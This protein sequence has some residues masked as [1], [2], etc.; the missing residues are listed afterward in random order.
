MQT[1]SERALEAACDEERYAELHTDLT[2][3][4]MYEGTGDLKVYHRLCFAS[5][6]PLINNSFQQTL[7][8]LDQENS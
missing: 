8:P 3:Q 7:K 6:V 5:K 2:E 4:A 1:E